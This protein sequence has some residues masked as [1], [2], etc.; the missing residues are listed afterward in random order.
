MGKVNFSIANA[1]TL[2]DF[3]K[4]FATVLSTQGLAVIEDDSFLRVIKERDTRYTP[5]SFY[6]SDNYPN[7]DQYILVKHDLKNPLAYEITRN[8]RPFLSRYARI[9]NFNDGHTIILSEKGHNTKRIIDIINNLDNKFNLEKFIAN[10]EARRKR[11][12]K[13]DENVDI[14]IL[15]MEKKMLQKEILE[16]KTSNKKSGKGRRS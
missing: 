3:N 6:T 8:M 7:N 4:M 14:D 12:K 15:K 16:L 1:I 5:S 10:K 13:K 11:N 9:I 2:E